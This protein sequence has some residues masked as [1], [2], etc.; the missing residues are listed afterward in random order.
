M[1]IIV[2]MAGTGRRFVEAGY[3]DPK[4][5]IH[6]NGKRLIEYIT[7]MFDTENDEFVFICNQTHIETTEMSSI[8]H[9]L[10]DKCT[11]IKIDDHKLGPVHSVLQCLEQINDDEQVIVTYC[12]N[13]YKWNYQDFIEY[14]S[15]NDLDGCILS[16]TGFHPHRLA[17]TYMAY[18]KMQD[19]L[20]VSEVKEKEPYT[21]DHWT[22]HASTGT[23][24]FKRGGDVKRYFKQ[25]IDQNVNFNNEYYVTLVYNLLIEDNLRVGVYDTDLVT[26]FGTPSELENFEAWCTILEG[27]QVKNEQDLINSYNY[28]KTYHGIS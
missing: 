6:A 28:W 13:P 21:D 7:K 27:S 5:L 17:S 14:V 23:Y 9:D 22:E 3:K 18:M 26:V 11:I 8:L 24:Y 10:V 19:E 12:D 16:H 4:P 2:P 20:L 25:C 1:K 15:N